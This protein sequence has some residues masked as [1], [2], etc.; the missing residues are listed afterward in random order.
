METGRVHYVV[1]SKKTGLPSIWHMPETDDEARTRAFASTMGE[2][3]LKRCGLIEEAEQ[4]QEEI[5]KKL[6]GLQ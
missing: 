2:E 4:L 1:I 6:Y 3:V 5:I